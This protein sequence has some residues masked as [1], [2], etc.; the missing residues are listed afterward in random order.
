MPGHE[1]MARSAVETVGAFKMGGLTPGQ[2]YQV[3]AW[4]RSPPGSGTAAI[5]LHD[6]TGAN[7]VSPAA[8]PGSATYQQIT[9][10]YVANGTGAV[11]V[12]LSFHGGGGSV[13]WDDVS[14]VAN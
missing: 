9:L 7:I 4:V 10:N 13:E 2:N 12:H 6:T 1:P 5:W 3:S 8:A 14:V 11:R